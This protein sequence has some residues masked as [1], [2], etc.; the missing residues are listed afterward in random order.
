MGFFIREPE[1]GHVVGQ[2]PH[3]FP[4]SIAIGYGLDGLT[5]A[6]RAIGVW[7]CSACSPSISPARGSFGAP[8]PQ[9]PRPA[10]GAQRHPGVVR[11]LSERR[12]RDAGAALR[13]AARAAPAPTSTATASSRR[14]PA[15]C[16]G[17]CCSCASTRCSASPA[18]WRRWRSRSSRARRVRWSFL[19]ALA[20]AAVLAGAVPARPDA[21]VRLPADR[22]RVE[23][24]VVAGRRDRRAGAGRLARWASWSA[25][26]SG[27]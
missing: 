26:A 5:G 22:L 13:G 12:G 11:A 1:H 9:R 17:C 7:A 18:C 20:A 16:S 4:A 23:P 21:R 3:L 8:Q 2:F 25:C 19:A 27:R 14:S 6:R 15:C 24:A 10:A